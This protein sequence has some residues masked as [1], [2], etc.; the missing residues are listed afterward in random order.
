MYAINCQ[1]PLDA[2]FA[3]V[4]DTKDA[5]IQSVK[6]DEREDINI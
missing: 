5:K 6:R 4:T 1:R 3:S 2:R